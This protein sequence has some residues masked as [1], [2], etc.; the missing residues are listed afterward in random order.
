MAAT[1]IPVVNPDGTVL[2]AAPKVCISASY[3]RLANT[4]AYAAKDAL[5]N[6][7]SGMVPL[8]FTG[9]A[10]ASGLSGTILNA[11]LIDDSA[12]STP[13]DF[14]L[15]MFDTIPTATGDNLAMSVSDADSLFYIGGIAFTVEKDAA[16]STLYRADQTYFPLPFKCTGTANLFGLIQVDN[17]YTPASAGVITVRLL[18]AQD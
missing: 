4:T 5:T 15:H 10:R 7:T 18:I 6:N 11:V 8:T 13:G 2:T 16:A 14:T 17:S 3:T 9:C 12:P 1:P